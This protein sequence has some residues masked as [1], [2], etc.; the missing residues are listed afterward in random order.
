MR[1]FWRPTRH[2][3]TSASRKPANNH[4]VARPTP[5]IHPAS[6]TLVTTLDQLQQLHSD[7][8]APPSPQPHPWTRAVAI[9]CEW[10][11]FHNRATKTPVSLLQLA[12]D[13]GRVWLL[14]LLALLCPLPNLLG[15][16]Y[17]LQGGNGL[18]WPRDVTD[19]E[20][21]LGTLLCELFTR[22]DIIKVGMLVYT[23]GCTSVLSYIRFVIR[24]WLCHCITTMVFQVGFRFQIDALRLM[25]SYPLL[26]PCWGPGAGSDHTL[27]AQQ[28]AAVAGT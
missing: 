2:V 27:A 8:L 1:A 7:L 9:D 18:C 6:V 13:A 17:A 20:A 5:S 28:L 23:C 11:P 4:T 3:I 15:T 19:E 12:D 22:D 10:Q 21:A 16:P 26:G 14:D 24:V 25:E